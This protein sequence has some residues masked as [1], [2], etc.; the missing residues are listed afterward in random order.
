[1][2]LYSGPAVCGASARGGV[3]CINAGQR[4]EATLDDLR[5]ACRM[6]TQW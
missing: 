2:K 4:I 5:R 6:R 3:R 1:M